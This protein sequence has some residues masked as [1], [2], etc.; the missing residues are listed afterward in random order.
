MNRRDA[1]KSLLAAP[2]AAAVP[3]EPPK[4]DL[5]TFLASPE[6]TTPIVLDGREKTRAGEEEIV[7]EYQRLDPQFPAE[8]GPRTFHAPSNIPIGSTGALR[9]PFIDE[10]C[11]L[12]VRELA[13]SGRRDAKGRRIFA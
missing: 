12:S 8:F 9:M 7:A 10:K 2:V 3:V 1:L 13:D 4:F 5:R 11:Y 6:W